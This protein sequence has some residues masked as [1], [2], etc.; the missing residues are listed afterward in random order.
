MNSTLALIA[1]HIERNWEI[2]TAAMGA[3]FVAGVCMMP[4][5]FPKNAQ[6]WWSWLRNTLQTAVPAA[7]T[8][9]EAHLATTVTT[10]TSTTTQEASSSSVP[11][12]IQPV[13]PAK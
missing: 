1:T 6:D 12:P 2:Y 8:R 3:L 10:P 9:Q 7:R 13:D 5:S 4:E 11:N